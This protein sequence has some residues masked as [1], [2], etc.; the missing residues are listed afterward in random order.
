MVSL[1]FSN[2]SWTSSSSSPHHS[3]H[4]HPTFEMGSS[5]S[6]PARKLGSEVASSVSRAVPSAAKPSA[7][8]TPAPSAAGKA[9]VPPT[10]YAA[11]MSKQGSQYAPPA[12]THREQETQRQQQQASE[13]KSA[14][15]MRD[16]Y[17][18]QFLQNLSRLGQVKV[19]KNATNYQ[20]VSA[21]TRPYFAHL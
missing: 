21:H 2:S 13:T 14:D 6:K 1:V 12:S 10:E 9:R 18:P 20:P 4:S 16:A 19:P 11:A 8:P 3:L 7:N 5:S 17:D 15:I